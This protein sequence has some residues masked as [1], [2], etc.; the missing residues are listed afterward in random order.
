VAER[1]P[2]LGLQ[3]LVVATFDVKRQV[4]PSALKAVDLHALP[5]ILMLPARRKEPPFALYSG[6]ARPKELLYFVQKHASFAFELP[7]NPHLTR[8]QHEAWK[9]QVGQLPAEKAQRAFEKLQRETGLER[10]EL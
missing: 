3:S 2:E 8:E 9:E 4:L 10:D 7:P 1:A 6:D 5:T